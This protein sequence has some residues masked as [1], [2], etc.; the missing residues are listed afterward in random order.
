MIEFSIPGPPQ[1]KERPRVERNPYTGK[2]HARTPEKTTKYED[3]VRLCC[4][5]KNSRIICPVMVHIEAVFPVPCS[6]SNKA[7]ERMYQ[8]LEAPCKK[9]DIDN[10]VKIILDALNGFLYCDDKQ[11]ISIMAKKRYVRFGENPH[12][13]VKVLE[14]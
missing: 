6:V 11:V 13:Y 1:G 8:G 5:N 7:K 2:I 12:V 14:A 3:F 9:P 10:I 4:G